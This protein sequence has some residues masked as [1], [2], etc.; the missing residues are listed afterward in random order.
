MSRDTVNYLVGGG[1]VL[2]GLVLYTGLILV[3][4]WTSYSRL[5]ERLAATVLTLYVLG[6]LVGAGVLGALAAIYFWG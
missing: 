1:A 3:P 5:W 4:A 6:V 2:F